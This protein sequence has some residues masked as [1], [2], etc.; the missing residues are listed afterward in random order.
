MPSKLSI[1]HKIFNKREMTA[2]GLKG[3][4]GKKKKN[5]NLRP[6]KIKYKTSPIP[7]GCMMIDN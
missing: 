1:C 5:T 3:L 4:R 7:G 2:L 6:T